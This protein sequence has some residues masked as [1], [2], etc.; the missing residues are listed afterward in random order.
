MKIKPPTDEEIAI[1][2]AAFDAE[3]EDISQEEMEYD[4]DEVL[5]A[6][7]Q[8]EQEVKSNLAI[9]R[10]SADL[11]EHGEILEPLRRYILAKLPLFKRTEIIELLSEIDPDFYDSVVNNRPVEEL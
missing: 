6:F 5:R 8:E 10:N 9:F 11:T 2:N 1:I 7:E 4:L 3:G